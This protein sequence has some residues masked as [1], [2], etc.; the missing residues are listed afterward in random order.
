M[1]IWLILTMIIKK[2][3]YWPLYWLWRYVGQ[4]QTRILVFV[5]HCKIGLNVVISWSFPCTVLCFEVKVNVCKFNRKCPAR[6]LPVPFLFVYGKFWIVFMQLISTKHIGG[7]IH[8]LNWHVFTS[9]HVFLT[10]QNDNDSHCGGIQCTLELFYG[11]FVLSGA[12]I[13][14]LYTIWAV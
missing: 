10:M 14:T 5:L 7:F 6:K 9:Y 11:V 1:H 8:T 13:I 12:Y 4:P 2:A 3:K